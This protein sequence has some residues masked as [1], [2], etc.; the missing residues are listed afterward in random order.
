LQTLGIFPWGRPP[1][2]SPPS[3]LA[4]I[5]RRLTPTLYP[6]ARAPGIATPAP[7][8]NLTLTHADTLP[9]RAR[10]RHRHARTPPQSH[11]RAF[12]RPSPPLSRAPEPGI[13]DVAE[14][15]AEQVRAEHGEADRDPGEEHQVG[16]LLRVLRGRD[17]EHAPPRRV[18]LRHPEPEERQRRLDEDSAPELSRAEDDELPYGVRQDVAEGDPKVPDAERPSRLH[19]LH[20]ADGQH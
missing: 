13:Q 2:P 11:A 5:S 4:A 3:P 15:V 19:V 18:R 1:G 20:L 14:G 17:G 12:W 8:R 7:R 10:T 16:R 9:L 6:C